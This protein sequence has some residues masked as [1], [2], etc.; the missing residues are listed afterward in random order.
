[1][2]KFIDFA[3]LKK[4]FSILEVAELLDLPIK[5]EGDKY[6]TSCPVCDTD[7]DR[8]IVITPSKEVFYCHAA[9]KGG[10]LIALAAHVEKLG[11]RDAAEF[12]HRSLTV[13]EKVGSSPNNVKSELQPLSYLEHN[14]DLVA[15]I[16]FDPEAAERLGIGYA[17]KGLMRG[18]VAIPLR[19]DDGV[20]L[21]YIGINNGR[22]PK[23]LQSTDTIIVAFRKKETA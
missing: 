12:I 21:G 1:M 18:T 23:D 9:G 14:H 5:K 7:D 15:Q 20:L 17:K 16:G 22:L 10:D 4:R 13:P 11:M 2:S 8:A 6:R 19:T 3:E